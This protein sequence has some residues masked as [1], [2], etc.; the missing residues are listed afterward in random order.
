LIAEDAMNRFRYAVAALLVVVFLPT[1]AGRAQDVFF[2]P[3]LKAKDIEATLGVDWYGVYLQDKK[4]GNCKIE[5]ARA[6]ETLV[7][8]FAMHMKLVAFDKQTEMK[9]TRVL[10][11]E[12]KAPY[13]LLKGVLQQ[14]GEPKSKI[15]ATRRD[16]G[17]D[18]QFAAA[19]KERMRKEMEPMFSL[20]D[21]IADEVWLR[22]GPKVGDKILARDLDLEDWKIDAV[23]S[24]LK[25]IKTSLVRGVEVKYYEVETESRKNKFAYLSRFDS[26][27]KMLSSK[28][29]T[30]E[31]R[32]ETEAQAKNT[33]Y[34]QDLFVL[35]M[36]KLDRAI[37]FTTTLT[38]LV[39]EVEGKEGDVLL[40]GPRQ[41]VVVENDKRLIKIGKKF[42]NVVKAD[43]K[44]VAENLAETNAYAI[45]DPKVMAMAKKAIGDAKTP[46]EKVKR[47]VA[48]VHDFIVPTGMASLP[49][50]H[51]LLEHKK[52]DCKSYALLTTT[53][54]RAAGVPARDVAGLLYMG[55]DAK[56]FGGHAWNEVVLNGMWVPIDATLNQT[57]LDAGHISFGDDRQASGAMLRSL[58]KLRFKVVE[59]KM[60]K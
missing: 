50:I 14:D 42:A 46:E 27:G 19:G 34:S 56:A 49:N 6:G 32:K 5:R 21:D 17:F 24:T 15:T 22:S 55:D 9:M 52:G 3:E 36:A 45:A 26:A 4:I 38:E 12:A 1:P 41:T 7:E 47:I 25:S 13:R 43:E 11:F 10:T 40:N 33:E 16:N 58:G 53:L 35:G 60:S 37:G 51:D 59:A 2:Q 18:Y 29:A 39:L 54:C 44:A 31:L 8:T 20:A 30:F 48:F 23:Q 57:E 28:L